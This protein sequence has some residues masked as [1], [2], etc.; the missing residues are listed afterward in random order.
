MTKQFLVP[1]YWCVRSR[2]RMRLQN[3]SQCFYCL[4]E[5]NLFENKLHPKLWRNTTLWWQP[6]WLLLCSLYMRKTSLFVY[7]IISVVGCECRPLWDDFHR[8]KSDQTLQDRDSWNEVS[9]LTVYAV[10][11]GSSR[12]LSQMLHLFRSKFHSFRLF[13]TSTMF[14]TNEA[15]EVCPM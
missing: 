15:C 10:W 1:R 9:Y 12:F 13:V 5:T 4:R 6:Q 2:G 8:Q 7:R 3:D 14:E 11:L